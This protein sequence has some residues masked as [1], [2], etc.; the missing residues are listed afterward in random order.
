MFT[1]IEKL[2]LISFHVLRF[3]REYIRYYSYKIFVKKP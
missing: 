1:K 3:E 2:A